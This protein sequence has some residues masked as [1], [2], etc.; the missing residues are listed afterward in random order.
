[1]SDVLDVRLLLEDV[2][3]SLVHLGVNLDVQLVQVLNR[4]QDQP[5]EDAFVPVELIDGHVVL[6]SEE[7]VDGVSFAFVNPSVVLPLVNRVKLLVEV[8]PEEADEVLLELVQVDLLFLESG[9]ENR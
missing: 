6:S 9:L 7:L 3:H 1:M 5:G 4:V 2:H 8:G